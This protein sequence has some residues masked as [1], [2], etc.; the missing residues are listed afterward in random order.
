[1]KFLPTKEKNSPELREGPQNEQIF[2]NYASENINMW[3]T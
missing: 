3:I 2:A 1:M